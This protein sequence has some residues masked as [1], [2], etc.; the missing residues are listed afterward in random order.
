MKVGLGSLGKTQRQKLTN[1]HQQLRIWRQDAN[2]LTQK[3][4]TCKMPYT[5]S[6]IGGKQLNVYDRNQLSF[7]TRD[8][9]LGTSSQIAEQKFPRKCLRRQ[10]SSSWIPSYAIGLDRFQRSLRYTNYW[11]SSLAMFQL[12]CGRGSTEKYELE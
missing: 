5:V 4:G 9:S 10:K 11:F 1:E 3:S 2:Q 7:I 6:A 8:L 12:S